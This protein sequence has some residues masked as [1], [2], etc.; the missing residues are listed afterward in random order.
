MDITERA[1]KAVDLKQHYGY[2]C[3]QAVT[4]A[5]ADQTGLSEEQ[6]NQLASGFCAGMGNMQATCGS[7]IGAGMIAGLKKEGNGTLRFT[8]QISE[9]F[10][11]K[12]GA[13]ACKDVKG[14]ETGKMICSCEDCVRNA[15]LAYGEVMGEDR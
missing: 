14:I 10:Q 3:C 2:N 9:K 4:A 6:L 13:L 5:L 7:L 15:V 12:S 11:E 8:R 1:K